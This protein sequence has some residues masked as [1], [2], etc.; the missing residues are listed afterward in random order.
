MIKQYT[1]ERCAT[2]QYWVITYHDGVKNRVDKVWT[3]DLDTYTLILER[4]GYMKAYTK[5]AVQEARE[6]Y[7]RLLARQLVEEAR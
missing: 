1:V 7:E 2:F 3:D 5:E 6:E 4:D